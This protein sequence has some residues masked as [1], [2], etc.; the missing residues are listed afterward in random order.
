L[1]QSKGDTKSLFNRL[2]SLRTVSSRNGNYNR[3]KDEEADLGGRR[4][5]S[6]EEGGET[7]GFLPG[8]SD[9]LQM[10]HYPKKLHTTVDAVQQQRELSEAGYEAEYERLE[11][12]LG[13]GMTSITERPFT[14]N[15]SPIGPGSYSRQPRRLPNTERTVAQAQTAQEQA[16]E[17]GGIIAAAVPIDISEFFGGNF[18][19]GSTQ[20]VNNG[21][22]KSYFFPK[23]PS[24]SDG[25][26]TQ[27]QANLF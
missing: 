22:Q 19:N 4:L 9:A 1:L 17:T 6:V 5:R 11:R 14:H 26:V 23:G 16:E 8:N 12:Q 3:I 20:L 10:G 24:T 7:I 25:V 18:E 13:E 15:S 21:I 27:K 2:A